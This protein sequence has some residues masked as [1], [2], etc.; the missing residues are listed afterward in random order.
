M[1]DYYELPYQINWFHDKEVFSEAER[2]RIISIKD[3]DE[4]VNW[5]NKHMKELSESLSEL[6]SFI[7]NIGVTE[8]F[9]D[10]YRD[11]FSSDLDPSNQ[12]FW[13]EHY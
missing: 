2:Y 10:L 8:E 1:C 7:N 5:S 13:E 12:E 3:D 6:N 11:K 9:R 4:K